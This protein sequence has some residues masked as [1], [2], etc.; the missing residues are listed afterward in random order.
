MDLARNNS[1]ALD[2][3]EAARSGL[4]AALRKISENGWSGVGTPLSANI[5]PYTW[6]DVTF[7][8]G[9]EKLTSGDPKYGE[10][11]FRLT[12]DSLGYASDPMDPTVRS[13]DHS[14]CVVRLV[15]RALVSDPANWSSLTSFTVSQW[16]N[17]N[18]NVQF[19]V[20]ISG[21]T[22]IWGKVQLATEYPAITTQR[23]R[24]LSDL[25]AR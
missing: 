19:P 9:D 12:I 5:T 24:Y 8:T 21:P 23:D 18:V 7:T 11:P 3:R 20:R 4:A 13:S 1:R 17:Q 15:R 25:N 14:R 2:A 22:K 10:Y 6:Y 16:A